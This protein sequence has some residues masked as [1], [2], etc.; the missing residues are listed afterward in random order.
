M[1]TAIKTRTCHICHINHLKA[2]YCILHNCRMFCTKGKPC[3]CGNNSE[4]STM[5]V[6]C[7]HGD[8]TG[9]RCNKCGGII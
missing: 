6:N 4:M 3:S 7:I 9:Y 1:I 5:F 8:C 2:D